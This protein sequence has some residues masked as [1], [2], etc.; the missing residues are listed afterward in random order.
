[1]SETRDPLVVRHLRFGW[2]CI[3]GF[4][5]LGICLEVMHGLKVDW[6]LGVANRTRRLM[7]TLAH[8]HGVLL[9]LV[10]VA[11]ALTLAHL[12][13][14]TAS[15]PT[16][17]HALVAATI[18]VPGGFFLGGLVIYDGDPGR[19]VLLLPVGAVF[20]VVAIGL[21]AWHVTRSTD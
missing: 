6:Y 17:S 21:T 14:G 15:W 5:T 7:F 16:A 4:L 1:M 20:L 9:G 11:F 3:L 19:G 12:G 10:N 8:A 2:W 13:R 18:L